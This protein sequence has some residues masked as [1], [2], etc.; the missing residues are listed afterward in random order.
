MKL[1]NL[2][3]ILVVL[4][5]TYSCM[6]QDKYSKISLFPS[7]KGLVMAGYQGWFNTPDDGANKGWTHY[8]QQGKFEPGFCKI[9]IW[10]DVSEYKKTYKT[11][12]VDS[13]GNT[14]YVYS[15]YDASTTDLHFKWMKEYGIDGVFMQRFI[16]ALKNQK[17]LNHNN[18]VLANA[19][20]S[21]EKY[22][23]AIAV[24]YDLSGMKDTDV[25]LICNDWKSLV[26]SLHIAN[27]GKKQS[28]LYHNN[29]P[30]VALWGVGFSGRKYSNT[31]IEKLMDFLQH[32]PVYGGCAVLLGVPTQW[33][34]LKGDAAKDSSSYALYK[35]AD[36]VQPWMVGR[37]KEANL[38]D[39]QVRI[40]EDLEWCKTNKIDF[41][42]VV[43]PGFSWHNMY[44][45]SPMNQIPRNRGQFFWKQLSSDIKT[46]VEM[47]Y[48]AMFDE[49]DEGTAILKSSKNPPVGKSNFVTVESDLPND[50]YLFLTGYAGKMLRKEMA[51]NSEVPLRSQK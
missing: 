23:R 18:T 48:I 12:F 11:P 41:V 26:D 24:M 38:S 15:S 36:I 50:Y 32:D 28:Y 37:Y 42:P 39:R 30:L 9:D 51:W 16:S 29:K 5:A 4:L 31:S 34:E 46:G 19:L 2:L 44:P 7:Y 40:K 35:R 3:L 33:R 6:A 43:Y 13:A 20:K 8:N 47:F 1:K 22:K 25:E 27:R 17:N 14:C 21:A 10:P 49:V 45:N